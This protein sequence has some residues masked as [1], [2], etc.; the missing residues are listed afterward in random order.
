MPHARVLIVDDD[1]DL[2]NAVA[3]QLQAEGFSTTEAATG[4]AGVSAAEGEKPDLVLLDVD[5]PDMD[6]REACREMRRR[7]VASPRWSPDG[8]HI[9]FFGRGTEQEGSGLMVADRDGSHVTFIAKVTGT[10]HPLQTSGDRFS[11]SPDGKRIA[12]VSATP[13]PEADANG[14]PMVITRY[15]YKPT[16]SEGMT[17]FNDNKRIHVF[18]AD[19]AS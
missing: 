12:F 15:L 19:L 3:E 4:A 17:R 9:A 7:G 8:S 2:R 16:A 5:L 1:A 13:G 6:G 11:W 18:V 10:N 14:D